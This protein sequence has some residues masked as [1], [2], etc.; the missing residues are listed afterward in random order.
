[1]ASINTNVGAQ[2]ALVNLSTTQYNLNVTQNRISTGL[3]VT[4][5]VDDA[6]DFA[7]AQGLRSN[8][9]AFSAV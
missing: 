9:N 1:M 4:G 6:A 5:P 2:V 3:K 7:I 8:I